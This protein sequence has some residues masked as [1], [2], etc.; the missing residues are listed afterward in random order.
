MNT[1]KIVS[2]AQTLFY[3]F[4]WVAVPLL[5]TALG[6]GGAL[7]GLLPGGTAVAVVWILNQIENAHQAQTGSAMF[8]ALD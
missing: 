4:F 1:S 2:L 7:Y 6:Q 8:G 5:V 3:G